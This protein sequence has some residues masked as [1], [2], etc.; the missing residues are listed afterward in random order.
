MRTAIYA[1]GPER[2]EFED[3]SAA[4]LAASVSKSLPAADPA[5]SYG[6]QDPPRLWRG[7]LHPP[8]SVA[9]IS[10]K[11]HVYKPTSELVSM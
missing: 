1:P 6:S 11:E 7:V 3:D 9:N 10:A 8:V 5:G 2:A 4:P